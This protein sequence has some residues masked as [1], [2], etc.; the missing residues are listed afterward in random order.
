MIQRGSGPRW[1]KN[2]ILESDLSLAKQDTAFCV[3]ID[4]DQ[5]SGER[6]QQTGTRTKQKRYILL[7]NNG[8]KLAESKKFKLYQQNNFN[9][10]GDRG[11]LIFFADPLALPNQSFSC[12]IR[13]SPTETPHGTHD[14]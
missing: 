4:T 6:L 2:I 5:G 13:L 11:V 7:A 9:W 1:Q 12:D 8:T 14:T 10:E 3:N